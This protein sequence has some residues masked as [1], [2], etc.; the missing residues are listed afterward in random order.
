M[1]FAPPHQ[2][3]QKRGEAVRASIHFTHAARARI[4]HAHASL[5]RH[6]ADR[7]N[8]NQI[9]NLLLA[10]GFVGGIAITKLAYELIGCP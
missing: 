2:K 10:V 7:L 9:A 1:K 3:R 5:V 8:L 4:H 6:I